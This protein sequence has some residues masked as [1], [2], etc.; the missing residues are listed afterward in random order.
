MAYGTQTIAGVDKIFGP[1]NAYVCEAKR[2]VFGAVGV[3]LLPGPSELMVI[4]DDSARPDFA[5]ADLLAQAEHGSGRERIYLVATSRKIIAARR[6]RDREAARGAHARRQDPAGAGRRVPGGRGVG[7]RPG[8]GGGQPGR[9][10]APGA[11]RRGRGRAR[12]RGGGHDRGGDHDRQRD[13]HGA[14]GLRGGPEPRPSDGRGRPVLQRAARRRFSAAHERRVATTRRASAA[15]G[16]S[17]R[18]SPPWSGWT[19][20]GGRS[21][22]GSQGPA[23]N[24]GGRTG[25]A[26]ARPRRE[27]PCLRSGPAALGARMGQAEHQRVPVPAEPEGRGGHPPR[28]RRRWRRR[29]GSIPIPRAP[30]CAR[31]WRGCHG[32]AEANVC[33][34]N[35]SDDILNLLVRCFCGPAAAAGFTLPGYSLYPVLSGSRTAAPCRSNWTGP[36]AFPWSG[37]RRPAPGCSSSPRPTRRPAS[38]FRTR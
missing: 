38:V 13:P 16:R 24:E 36:C 17:S 37:S 8:R 11:P 29:S 19:P 18:S 27:A 15:P 23:P 10:R 6:R 35:G 3:D 1:G 12:A 31:R 9:A 7:A 20:T 21:R 33:I 4:A 25:A 28:G 30:P 34:G 5:A 22:F 14:G 2:Q 32:V 26:R